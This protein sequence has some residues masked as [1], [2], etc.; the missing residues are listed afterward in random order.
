MQLQRSVEVGAGGGLAM[1]RMS[2]AATQHQ[3][4]GAVGADEKRGYQ[5]RLGARPILV[6]RIGA[7]A[8]GQDV[9]ICGIDCE[10]CGE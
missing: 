3:Q 4:V 6:H 2:R 7:G 9:S 8:I 5:I 10:R 1:Q